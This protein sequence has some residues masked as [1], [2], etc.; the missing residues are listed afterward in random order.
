MNGAGDLRYLLSV[1]VIGIFSGI[2]R[3]GG[4]S[5]A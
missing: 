3:P 1:R 5:R 2:L 4:L